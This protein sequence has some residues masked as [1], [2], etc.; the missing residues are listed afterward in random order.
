MRGDRAVVDALADSG[1]VTAACSFRACDRGLGAN[2]AKVGGDLV[3]KHLLQAEPEQMRR[4]AAVGS[5][6]DVA[7]DAGRSARAAVT[8]R[9]AVGETGADRKIDVDVAAAVAGER[10]VTFFT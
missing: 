3:G 4:V 7:A 6:H 5:R 1:R 9:A 8:S 2:L 10:A